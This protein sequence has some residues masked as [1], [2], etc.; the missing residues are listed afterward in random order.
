LNWPSVLA[1][2]FTSSSM[3]GI[4]GLFTTLLNSIEKRPS[5]VADRALTRSSVLRPQLS[6]FP[7]TSYHGEKT[8][9]GPSGSRAGRSHVNQSTRTLFRNRAGMCRSGRPP[10]V[11]RRGG[12]LPFPVPCEC[13][14]A[15]QVSD[16][17]FDLEG[18]P[19][20]GN[21]RFLR[22]S[23]RKSF[24]DSYTDKEVRIRHK[25]GKFM[26]DLDVVM[27]RNEEAAPESDQNVMRR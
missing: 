25:L 18:I 14:G 12:V 8:D 1:A 10:H 5:F 11:D 27:P 19:A 2:G 13:P 21:F 23:N 17:R 16:W 26:E 7:Q 3:T 22:G 15:R 9:G 6:L 20:G 24:R 4:A